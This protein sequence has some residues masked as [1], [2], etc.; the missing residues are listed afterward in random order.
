MPNRVDVVAV[1]GHVVEASSS[2][3]SRFLVLV[4]V[5]ILGIYGIVDAALIVRIVD[6]VAF[7]AANARAVGGAFPPTSCK[8]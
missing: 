7:G 3:C 1:A 8:A 2:T 6:E 4:L 5:L